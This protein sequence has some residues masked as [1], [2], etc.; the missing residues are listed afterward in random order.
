M[1]NDTNLD[2]PSLLRKFPFIFYL[3]YFDGFPQGRAAGEQCGAQVL[4]RP[5]WLAA[6]G[7]E[8]Q[9]HRGRQVG[10]CHSGGDFLDEFGISFIK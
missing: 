8:R 3:F 9:A 7:E 6:D 2:S 10:D 5:A 1:E 4:P